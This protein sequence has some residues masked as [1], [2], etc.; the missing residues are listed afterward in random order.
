M[1]AQVKNAVHREGTEEK[2]EE[3]TVLPVGV[4][5][6]RQRVKAGITNYETVYT[7]VVGTILA[8]VVR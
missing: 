2:R 7:A 8:V 1:G 6:L 4:R 3:I 5:G